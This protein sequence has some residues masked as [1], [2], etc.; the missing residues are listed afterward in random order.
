MGAVR[1][2]NGRL[3]KDYEYFMTAIPRSYSTR[4]RVNTR[5]RRSGHLNDG[6]NTIRVWLDNYAAA[7]ALGRSLMLL[8]RR[9]YGLE[10]SA[11]PQG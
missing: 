3:L 2:R 6:E 8:L 5:G 7:L 9:R 11:F 10:E 4:K 1:C